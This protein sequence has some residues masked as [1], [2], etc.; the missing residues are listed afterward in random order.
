M[1]RRV[2]P[3]GR[4]L[5][6]TF[7]A[8]ATLLADAVG[9][10]YA[11][12][13]ANVKSPLGIN[14]STVSYYSSEQPFLNIFV[15]NGGWITHGKKGGDT[16]EEQYLQ[17]DAH[18]YPKTLR[19]SLSDPHS[20]QLFDSV[21]VLLD[22]QGQYGYPGGRYVVLYDGVGK[23][24]YG[25][26]A[27][28]VSSSPGRD[29]IDVA[30]PSPAGIELEIRATDPRH[31]GSYVRNI[32]V[33]RERDEGAL[34]AGRLF[35]PAFLNLVARFRVLRFMDWLRTNGNTLSSW[36]K[37]PVPSDYS[38]ATPAGVPI[39]VAVEL[40]NAVSADA[41]LNVPIM[42]DDAYIKRMAELVHRR[43]GPM[44]K[45]YLE[46]SN[47]VWNS[48]FP[49]YRYASTRGQALWPDRP[50]GS[51]GYEWNRN[52]YGMRTAQ[53]CDIWKSIWG[54]DTDR[55]ICVLAAQA[56]W[57]YSATDALD[58]S[59]WSAGA[60][61]SRH[62]LGAV[63]IA[64]YFGDGR[65]PSQ[66]GTQPDGGLTVLFGS[67]GSPDASGTPPAADQFSGL[68]T[69]VRAK[70]ARYH[71]IAPLASDADSG[72]PAGGWFHQT[73]QWE[74]SYAMVAAHYH[75]PL[76]GYEGGQ[77]F[78]GGSESAIRLFIAA[79]HDP[80]MGAAYMAYLRQ[81]KANG[82]ELLVLYNDVGA[83]SQYGEWGA[84]QSL[85]QLNESATDLPPKWRAIQ[86]F[87]TSTACWWPGCKGELAAGKA[88]EQ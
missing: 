32:R 75:I 3:L 42:A 62:G 21:D 40:A 9:P 49:Q 56:A 68:I 50:P 1:P 79:N 45:V 52:W 35:N 6:S 25:Y 37:R 39:E 82:G 16:G 51:N 54:T 5:G 69:R 67:L 76:I 26:D 64:P 60:P 81:W 2:A 47:E 57:T 36:S 7:L 12:T 13:P 27:R 14:L 34:G 58:C 48:S 43:L 55:V 31:D 38:W 8:A 66:W 28:L 46:Y 74:S 41:W 87:I 71:F 23:L 53:T 70:L 44:Q 88:V 20:P 84:L 24:A 18:G 80:R 17:L 85:M 59:Y 65:P 78:V 30:H 29:V 63:A 19:A 61:C 33:V 77:G 83:Y 4:L 73:G 72:V 15:T 22:C 86:N 11:A 10:A